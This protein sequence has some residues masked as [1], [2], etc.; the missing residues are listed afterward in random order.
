MLTWAGVL[1]IAALLAKAW[2]ARQPNLVWAMGIFLVAT[3][4]LQ[5]LRNRLPGSFIFMLVLAALLNGAGGTYDWFNVY[6]WFDESVHTYT[7]FAGMAAIG[8]VWAGDGDARGERRRER[9]VW[10]CAGLGL[11]LGIGWE[12]IEEVIGDL[13]FWD[14]ASDLVLDTI[15]AALGGLFAR[16]A[17]RVSPPAAR[18]RLG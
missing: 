6:A 15:G 7:G 1:L 18:P 2:I 9:L 11:V 12:V 10:W 4:A 16:H 3:L 8:H 13:E 17:L 14:T 5:L